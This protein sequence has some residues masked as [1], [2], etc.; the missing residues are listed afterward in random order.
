MII[1]GERESHEGRIKINQIGVAL[2]AYMAFAKEFGIELLLPLRHIRSNERIA[3]IAG[4][5]WEEDTEQVECVL[6]KNYMETNNRVSY[7]ELAI[8]RFL[9][10]FAVQKAKEVVKKFLSAIEQ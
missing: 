9:K 10:E 6:S 5:D 2:E 3:A 7:S 1:A 4:H 8:E